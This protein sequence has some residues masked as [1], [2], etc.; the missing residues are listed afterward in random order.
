MSFG[1]LAA[2]GA[3]D[4]PALELLS[5]FLSVWSPQPATSRVPAT[6]RAPTAAIRER[7]AVV[8]RVELAVMVASSGEM[9]CADGSTRTH[10]FG[11]RD[12]A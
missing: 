8:R 12:L 2:S 3:E 10:T 11:C 5:L 9:G 4:V 7:V 6:A 1:S